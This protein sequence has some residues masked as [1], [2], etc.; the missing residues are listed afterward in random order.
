MKI[1]LD[2]SEIKLAYDIIKEREDYFRKQSE[3]KVPFVGDYSE[4]ILNYVTPL[5]EK[6]E[7]Y[8]K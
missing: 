1:E 2:E 4:R 8:I 5:R 3:S 6:I 7:K